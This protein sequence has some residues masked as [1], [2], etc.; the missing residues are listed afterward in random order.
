[1]LPFK[2]N[3]DL[4]R[5]NRKSDSTCKSMSSGISLLSS[6]LFSS[7]LS[8]SI[9]PMSNCQIHS[10]YVSLPPTSSLPSDF[11]QRGLRRFRLLTLWKFN[12]QPRQHSL[13]SIYADGDG[14]GDGDHNIHKSHKVGDFP[15]SLSPLLRWI[16][17]EKL[18][19]DM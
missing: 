17:A 3:C 10:S 8:F 16:R 18:D 5:V 6:R 4:F 7:L 2:V 1:M 19:I 13:G 12:L 15:L 9:Y 14:N 11:F